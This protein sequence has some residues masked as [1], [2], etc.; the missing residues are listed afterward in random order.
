MI[1][2]TYD[3]ARLGCIPETR[4]LVLKQHIFVEYRSMGRDEAHHLIG[5]FTFLNYLN[6]CSSITARSQGAS[7]R[8]ADLATALPVITSFPALYG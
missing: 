1:G 8:F 4:M 2:M 7:V 3:D 5:R 6:A